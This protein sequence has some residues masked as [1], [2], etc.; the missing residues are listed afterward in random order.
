MTM[1]RESATLLR[2]QVLM[3]VSK[4]AVCSQISSN[5]ESKYAVPAQGLAA[6]PAL[7]QDA[8]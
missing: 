7:W 4:V 1:R 3:A 2:S 6:N 5:D 8:R